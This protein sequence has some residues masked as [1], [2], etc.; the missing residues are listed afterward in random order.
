VSAQLIEIKKNLVV[1]GSAGVTDGV[2]FAGCAW[3]AGPR[4][5]AFLALGAIDLKPVR[6]ANVRDRYG[7]GTSRTNCK[8]RTSPG[9]DRFFRKFA[10]P[11]K[12]TNIR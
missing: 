12:R 11:Q 10:F 5:T 9:R 3:L 1:P 7:S 2:A 4:S 8:H 6:S